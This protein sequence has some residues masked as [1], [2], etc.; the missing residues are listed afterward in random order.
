MKIETIID[1][2][3]LRRRA[4]KEMDAVVERLYQEQINSLFRSPGYFNEKPGLLN[5]EIRSRIETLVL[6]HASEK[7]DASIKKQFDS[8]Y[9]AAYNNALEEAV[10][11]EAKK[12]ANLDV[13][14]LLKQLR[15]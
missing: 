7:M 11:R 1:E 6:E 13:Q 9:I 2:D 14:E 12:R 5:T 15:K 4:K 3:E 8:M 10:I